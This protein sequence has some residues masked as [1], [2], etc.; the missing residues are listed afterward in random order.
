[1]YQWF[2]FVHLAGVFGLLAAHG[3][4]MVV[5]FRLRTERDPARIDGLLQLSAAS[6]TP[7]WISTVVLLVGGIVA[8]FL[9]DLWSY[10]WIWAAVGTLVVIIVA[11]FAMARP[12][13]RRVRFISRAMAEG[14]QAVS[15]EQFDRILSSGR[16]W[17]VAVVGFG[18]LAFILYLMLFKPE[19]GLAPEG[20]AA[21]AAGTAVH[22]AAEELSFSTDRLEAPAGESFR[23]VFENDGSVPHNVSI[24]RGENALFEGEVVTGPTRV[25]YS[26]PALERGEYVFVCDIHPEM[27][28]TLVAR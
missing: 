4:S 23:L 6:I 20:T 11:M 7:F 2:V 17:A 22:I 28:G 12:Y 18:G 25:T 1:V 19:L 24:H 3:V 15:P 8:A 16:P 10:G 26:V 14:S 21:R 27:T 9:G 13:Y 5:M